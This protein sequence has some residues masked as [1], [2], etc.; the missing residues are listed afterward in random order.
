MR[1]TSSY[2]SAVISR[3]A[4][5]RRRRHSRPGYRGRRTRRPFVDQPLDIVVARV[6]RLDRDRLTAS[7]ADTGRHC[8]D[9]VNI[10]MAVDHDPGAE[11][12]KTS[13]TD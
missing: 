2:S 5:W 3:S 13:A 7:F 10:G 8:L 9:G 12:R 4:R 11:R 1:I 6:G